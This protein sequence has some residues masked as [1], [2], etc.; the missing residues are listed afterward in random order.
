M[1]ISHFYCKAMNSLSIFR[2]RMIFFCF[3]EPSLL[4]SSMQKRKEKLGRFI[5][6]FLPVLNI[7]IRLHFVFSF[8]GHAAANFS[9]S[10]FSNF[11]S[12]LPFSR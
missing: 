3:I 9:R 1:T 12:F 4:F 11:C 8:F 7:P 10:L 6:V 2:I 5:Q